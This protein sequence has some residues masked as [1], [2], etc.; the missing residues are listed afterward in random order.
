MRIHSIITSLFVL[1]NFL[2]AV[3]HA[4]EQP[5]ISLFDGKTLKGWIV[6]GGSAEVVNGELRLSTKATLCPAD[7]KQPSGFNDFD[8]L[9]EVRTEPGA[10][11][12]I[13]FK[14]NSNPHGDICVAINNSRNGADWAPKTGSLAKVRREYKSIVRD[15]QWFELRIRQHDHQTSVW[16]DN[17]LL[18]QKVFLGLSKGPL[19]IRAGAATAKVCFKKHADS[20]AENSRTVSPCA[21]DAGRTFRGRRSPP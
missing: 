18:V 2:V 13:C 12:D 5:S 10:T 11:A 8:F 14:G 19:T 15:G 7:E 3:V 6:Q 1:V 21:A 4:E 16:V 20:A 17:V 9:T